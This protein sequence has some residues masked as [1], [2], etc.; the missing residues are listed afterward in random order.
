[1]HWTCFLRILSVQPKNILNNGLNNFLSK[2]N[3]TSL[4]KAVL[5]KEYGSPDVLKLDRVP[6]PSKGNSEV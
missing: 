1:M 5:L 2:R 4:M 6:I 3:C